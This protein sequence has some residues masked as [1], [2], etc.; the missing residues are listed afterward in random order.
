MWSAYPQAGN[1]VALP[2]YVL[3]QMNVGVLFANGKR[4]EKIFLYS[5]RLQK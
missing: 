1:A 2:L 5:N 3:K 4:F